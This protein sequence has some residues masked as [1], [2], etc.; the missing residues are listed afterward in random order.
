MTVTTITKHRRALQIALGVIWLIDAALQC[1]PYFFGRDFVTQF[2]RP[3]ATG[4]PWFVY[5]PMVWA[6]NFMVHDI[7]LWNTLFATI[8]LLIAVGLF[9]RPTVRSALA[10]SVVWSLG[11][12][13]FGEGLGGIFQTGASPLNGGP[14]AVILY[15]LLAVLLWP[16]QQDDEVVSVAESG[17]IGRVAPEVI[18]AVLW[19]SFSYFLVVG[20]NRSSQGIHDMVV[21]MSTGE[22]HW[23]GSLDR[24]LASPTDHAG[25]AV[26]IVLAVV[27]A[28]IAASVVMPV[29][30][31][32]AL[33]VAGVFALAIWCVEDFGAVLTSTGTDVNS[34]PLL[35]LL[36]WAYWPLTAVEGP[37]KGGRLT[38][39]LGP[40]P[41]PVS[42]QPEAAEWAAVSNTAP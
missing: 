34:G 39:R 19:G 31:R 36:A 18:W 32:P 3:L 7:A 10:V 28:A 8:Q 16:R 12:W 1:K 20:A 29:L 24:G 22:P 30:R 40:K 33:I 15:A 11:V 35:I 2:L 5:H 38:S 27:C 17:P 23:V 4:N 26:S 9:W 21:G 13:W 14:G 6:D 42:Q 41:A 37:P 25:L